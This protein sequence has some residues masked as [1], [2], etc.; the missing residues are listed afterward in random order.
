LDFVRVLSRIALLAAAKELAEE[1]EEEEEEEEAA[2]VE[3]VAEI[4]RSGERPLLA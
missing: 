3:P 2:A 4:E 1:E